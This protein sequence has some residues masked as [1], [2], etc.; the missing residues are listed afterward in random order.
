MTA[1]LRAILFPPPNHENTDNPLGSAFA[2]TVLAV[3]VQGLTRLGYSILVA[4]LLGQEALSDVNTVISLA[5]LLV[6]LWP[7]AGGTTVSKFT[8]TAGRAARRGRSPC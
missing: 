6:L 4:R 7:Q 3:F 2:L 1:R 8:A 5:S